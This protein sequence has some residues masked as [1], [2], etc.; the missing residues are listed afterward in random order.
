MSNRN[1]LETLADECA[2]TS[3]NAVAKRLNLSSA[4]VSQVLRKKYPGDLERIKKLV[5]G[6]F[7]QFTVNCP[8]VGEITKDKCLSHQD[9]PF[10]STN[11]Q[12]VC[13]YKAC[14]S[15]C[16]H[17]SLTE[18]LKR[19]MKLTFEAG[20]TVRKYDYQGAIR[21]LT[22]Q[23]EGGNNLANAKQLI[24]LLSNELEVLAIKY[25]RLIKKQK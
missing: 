4:T 22:V 7:M 15:G 21:R 16:P 20:N 18:Q 24:N 10:A 1:W 14:R 19:P 25:N 9:A 11:P 3:Q 13:L 17:S 8:I 5:E 12:R 6:A 2:R 23:A